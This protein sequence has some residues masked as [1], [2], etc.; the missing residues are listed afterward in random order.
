MSRSFLSIAAAMLFSAT[1]IALAAEDHGHVAKHGGLVQE[2]GH[3]HI[4][5]VAKDGSLELYVEG[6][7]GAPEDVAAAQATAVVLSDGKKHDVALTAA[8]GGHLKGAG[9]FK[10]V[11]GTTIVVTLTMPGHA[12][13][14]ARFKLD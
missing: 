3:H 12:P 6:E 7:N 4:E 9:D 2:S 1:T 8:A 10:A 13:E 11:K 14:Q 5:L